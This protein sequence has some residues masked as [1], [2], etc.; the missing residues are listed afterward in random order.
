[1][2]TYYHAISSPKNTYLHKNIIIQDDFTCDIVEAGCVQEPRE[3]LEA[4]D[5]VNDYDKEY[6]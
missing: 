1:M 3:E 4:N 5:G 2:T 6:E